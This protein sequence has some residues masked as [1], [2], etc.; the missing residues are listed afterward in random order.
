MGD[1]RVSIVD[2]D[3]GQP[4]R[5]RAGC[6]VAHHTDAVDA[7]PRQDVVVLAGAHV[8]RAVGEPDDLL[9][10]R[11]RLCWLGGVQFVPQ[12]A[13]GRRRRVGLVA[14]GV[15]EQTQF[16]PLWVGDAG[17]PAYVRE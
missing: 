1:R 17:L 12:P 10:K 6:Q 13:A 7:I 14:S 8:H 16:S 11:W 5:R 3:L 9:V 4:V 2:G 15:R